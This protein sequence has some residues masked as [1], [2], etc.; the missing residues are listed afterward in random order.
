MESIHYCLGLD[1]PVQEETY[2]RLQMPDQWGFREGDRLFVDACL[3]GGAPAVTAMDG[4]KSVQISL[5]CYESARDRR[6]IHL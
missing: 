5:A 2:C 1:Q 6:T 4:F 3:S